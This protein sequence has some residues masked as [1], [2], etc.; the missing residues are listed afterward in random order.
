MI[1]VGLGWFLVGYIILWAVELSR[2]WFRLGWRSTVLAIG[3]TVAVL[4]H[5]AFIFDRFRSVQQLS[6]HWS[7]PATLF[8]WGQIAAWGLALAYLMLI[9]RRPNSTFGIFILPIVVTI[10]LATLLV[11]GSAPFNRGSD[12]TTLWAYV[13]GGALSAALVS[14]SLG[15][16]CAI[17]RVWQQRRLK[18]KRGVGGPM[19]L[20]SLEY[21]DGLGRTCLIASTASI[22]I[23]LVS[24]VIINASKAQG[25][26]W[27][28]PGILMSGGLLIWLVIAIAIESRAS[29]RGDSA[30]VLL[31]VVTFLITIVSMAV[32]FVNAHGRDGSGAG[33]VVLHQFRV[34]QLVARQQDAEHEAAL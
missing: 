16:V 13:H 17:M 29:T 27:G 12:M 25:V 15:L 10:I 3:T 11:Q 14:V 18:S 1:G 6:D 32:V 7:I 21:L 8:D 9:L 23:G 4:L 26:P 34:H 5:A 2:L 22:A 24:G 20:P 19:R 31:N 28:E 33:E 30:A